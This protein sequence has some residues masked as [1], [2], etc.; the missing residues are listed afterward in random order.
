[1]ATIDCLKE[2]SLAGDVYAMCRLGYKFLMSSKYYDVSE[3][4]KYFEMATT[5]GC[6][7][8]MYELG[9]IYWTAVGHMNS[10]KAKKYFEMA[11]E[12][13]HIKAMNDLGLFYERNDVCKNIP[14]AI[15]HYKMAIKNDCAE[16]MYNLGNLH[17][18]INRNIPKAIKYYKM[19]AETATL[20][21]T[22]AMRRLGKLYSKNSDYTDIPQAIRYFEMAIENGD[23]DA[24]ELLQSLYINDTSL[25][26]DLIRE[27]L[28]Q[29]Q[30]IHEL[31]QFGKRS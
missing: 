30:Q 29:R 23:D 28:E 24:M 19:A 27:H 12:H 18:K 4:I 22:D 11:V 15:K 31:E 16:A 5:L 20:K 26:A 14:D 3:A 10:F 25:F 1:M 13:G 8:A 9:T 6:S 21:D 2:N 7:S 17:E